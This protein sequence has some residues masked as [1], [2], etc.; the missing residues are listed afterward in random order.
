MSPPPPNPRYYHTLTT[1]PH[2][3]IQPTTTTNAAAARRA[4]SPPPRPHRFEGGALLSVS[5]PAAPAPGPPLLPSSSAAAAAA[6]QGLARAP[7]PVPYA[8]PLTEL[9]AG[10]T[11]VSWLPPVE[12]RCA[13]CR[14]PYDGAVSSLTL[15]H[16]PLHFLILPPFSFCSFWR[17]E[18]YT[19]ENGDEQ[20]TG[21]ERSTP[22]EKREQ[23]VRVPGCLR[24]PET[25]PEGHHVGRRCLAQWQSVGSSVAC[26]LCAFEG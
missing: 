14:M 3:P 16:L 19:D 13:L 20:G 21:L 11:L 2:R 5:P 9:A 26:P 8:V 7:R 1:L 23:A 24:N 25:A 6:L 4:L 12:R 15:S 10:R 22:W 18:C 17:G